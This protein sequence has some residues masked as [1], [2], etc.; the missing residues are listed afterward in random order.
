M[1]YSVVS[2]EL[3]FR[4]FIN[5]SLVHDKKHILLKI[6]KISVIKF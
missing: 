2:I 5:F 4:K 1:N 6:N 3:F